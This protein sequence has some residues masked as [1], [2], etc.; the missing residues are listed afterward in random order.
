MLRTV[1]EYVRAE[2]RRALARE[3]ALRVLTR[4]EVGAEA[5]AL[6]HVAVEMDVP[7]STLTY[8]Y[9]STG[10]LLDDLVDEYNRALWSSL[11]DGVGTAG[12]RTELEVAARRFAIDVLGDPGSR[13]LILWR[14]QALARNEWSRAEISV[15]HATALIDVI[16]E[17][18]G[19]H[20]RVPHRVLA[21]LILSYTFGQVVQW[22]GTRDEQAYWSTILAGIDGA[23][24]LADPRPVDEPH[25][26]PTPRDYG[27]APVPRSRDRSASHPRIPSGSSR[28][29]TPVAEP[30]PR[31]T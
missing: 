25:P 18:A 23:A 12:L 8:A 27:S 22:L 17:R 10:L 21:Q 5:I 24:L 26:E 4:G 19:E 1:A 29:A 20:Y 31:A 13:A 9:P 2:Q 28:G 6:R 16:A 14:I 30:Q 3:A 7:L 15:E 11:T